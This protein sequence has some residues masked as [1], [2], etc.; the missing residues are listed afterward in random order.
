MSFPVDRLISIEL[1]IRAQPQL[2]EGLD[3]WLRLGLLSE[4]QVKQ[5]CQT[6]LVCV[7]PQPATEDHQASQLTLS[8]EPHVAQGLPVGN[9]P[10]VI[11]S[12]S[13]ARAISRSPLARL[14]QSL[15]AELSVR[16]LLFLGVFMV[17]TSSGVL[18]AS[19]W[20]RFPASGQYAV[21]LGYT[22]MFWGV[23]F[24]AG[25]QQNLHLTAQTLQIV[26]LLLVPVNFWAM[27]S[28]GLWQHPWEW[29]T[30]ATA[31][32]ILTAIAILLLKNSFPLAPPR[33][34]QSQR[35]SI[36]TILGLSYLHWG[37]RLPGF[38]FIAVYL[39]IVGTTL[40]SAYQVHCRKQQS[41]PS[42][43]SVNASASSRRLLVN[44]PPIAVI[45]ALV[46]LLVRA[47]FVV[48]L[49][50]TQLGLA[51]GI[52]GWLVV[53]LSQ[54]DKAVAGVHSRELLQEPEAG[55][56]PLMLHS[57]LLEWTGGGLLFLGWTV[58]VT[59]AFPWQAAAV[60]GLSL[61][62]FID[63]LQ[64]FWR[65]IDLVA[66]F[67]IGLQT[68]WLIWQLVPPSIQ[69]WAIA[70]ATQLSD[71]LIAPWGLLSLILFPYLILMAGVTDWLYY[72]DKPD[73]GR[74][75]ER[76]T[77]TFG[78]VLTLL[79]LFEPWT[80][81]LNLLL[82]TM[83]LGILTQRRLSTA[84]DG[85]LVRVYLT[86]IVGLLSLGST[87]DSLWPQLNLTIWTSSLL[88]FMV[89]EWGFSLI[90]ERRAAHVPKPGSILWQQSAWHLGLGLAGLSYALLLAN[91]PLVSNP[92]SYEQAWGLL[93]LLTPLTLTGLASQTASSRRSIRS[94]L[95]VV[96]LGMAQV[97]TLSLPDIRIIS[98]GVAT[99]LMLLNT[100]Y[101]RSPTAAVTTVGFG[102]GCT[103]LLVWDRVLGMPLLLEPTW[104]LVGAIALSSLWFLRDWLLK[105]P[106][107]LGALYARAM[108]RWA[109]V[110]C[111]L[112]LTLLTIH[113][114]G[115]YWAVVSPMVIVLIATALTLGA[116]AYRSQQQ[117]SNWAF[118]GLGWCLEL[119]TA[120]ALG[121]AGHSVINLA[122]ANIALGLTTQLLGDRWQRRFG[123]V[124]SSWHILP[125]LYGVLGVGLRWGI[126]A[127]WTGWS[128]LS[129]ALIAIGIG[130]RQP[131]LKLLVYLGIAGVTISA[132][133]LL[134]YQLSQVPEVAW[135][136]GLM[137]MAA[138]STS[139]LYAYRVLTPWLI[140]YLRLSA[141]ELKI[142]AH[143]HWAWGSFL[144]V[145]AITMSLTNT[146]LGLW[147]GLFLARY[148]MFQGC[149]TVN[150]K[151]ADT[152][153]Y[154]GLVEAAGVGLYLITT[155]LLKGFSEPLAP[156]GAAIACVVAY[157]LYLLPWEAWGWSPRPWQRAAIILPLIVIGET[158]SIIHPASLLTAAAFYVL[159]TWLK[160]HI[161][162]TYL[163]LGLVN[164]AIAHW[165]LALQLADPMWYITP[166]GLSLLY[167]A[168]WDPSL[169]LPANRQA[170]HFLRLLGTG[171]ICLVALVLHH[172]TGLLPGLMSLSAIFAGLA[173][174]VRAYFYIGIV[175]FLSTAFYQLVILIL[176]YPFFKWVIGLL[177]GIA[178]IWI[179]AQFE[180]RREQLG[181]LV[182]NW[183]TQWQ[184]W[185]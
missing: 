91:T 99:G 110:L 43:S 87:I 174:R 111:G 177:V 123:T 124:P 7:L 2:L 107:V 90:S 129:V 37:W 108:D 92:A 161:R 183:G 153:V 176:D 141:A 16:W 55:G 155:P 35:L 66:I 125:L 49:P 45:Y 96:T 51:I 132:H 94:Q 148:A 62:F 78:I 166:I 162:F 63:R 122:I 33:L 84:G 146:S 44:L 13:T 137:A 139:L 151:W 54:Q 109:I 136:N 102:L 126:F 17:V 135:G 23:G 27:D 76:L 88:A 46:V 116:I 25:K 29:F 160:A 171:I 59:A 20:Q 147:T 41:L 118:Y 121:F 86:H 15:T 77:L 152:W 67:G 30:V 127:S 131:E 85:G 175:T 105:H 100:R 36:L 34:R 106:G 69:A 14:L 24:W 70:T 119:L 80:R 89:A 168:Q 182:R 4:A 32:C 164:W 6:Y 95:S 26:T 173:L 73:L 71:S 142:I 65:S 130:R 138:L 179:A 38:P 22:L 143:L 28:F 184:E 61:W 56:I 48:C 8:S 101:L 159:V 167:I 97:L 128:S 172:Q 178:F 156:F 154:L 81:S 169:K 31:A 144:G 158:S 133:E 42:I 12:L 104:F 79:S 19:Q 150:P 1:S 103:G 180:T 3:A 117:P 115:V 21:L 149:H 72:R 68:T 112:E 83:T 82:S 120:E 52:C 134:F 114:L 10:A 181:S 47:I 53:W 93:W 5:L 40:V 170:R 157:C 185:E 165:F 39:G 60:S 11:S 74:Y 75:S 140:T 9:T 18:A 50:V 145:A 98:L 57:S 58:S 163:S 64:R 113:S